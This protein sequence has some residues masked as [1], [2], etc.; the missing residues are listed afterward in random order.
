MTLVTWAI[1]LISSVGFIVLLY[2]AYNLFKVWA[3]STYKYI[4]NHPK[5]C[6]DIDAFVG[7]ENP[8]NAVKVVLAYQIQIGMKR[9]ASVE[10]IHLECY[11]SPHV[12]KLYVSRKLGTNTDVAISNVTNLQSFEQLL[13]SSNNK[14]T[15]IIIATIRMGFG[16]HRLAYSAAS[17]AIETGHPT[18]FH[19]LL[20]VKSR[21]LI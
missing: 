14:K 13:A 17:W 9:V 12:P 7:P 8:V 21:K 3:H 4:K 18:I 10:P 15:P 5:T 20:N 19:D 11:E 1:V 2:V 16:H 6:C